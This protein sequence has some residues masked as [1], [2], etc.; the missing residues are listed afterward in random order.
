MRSQRLLGR[1][2]AG[3][4]C[5]S[6]GRGLGG[7]HDDGRGVVMT[8]PPPGRRAARTTKAVSEMLARLTPPAMAN[9]RRDAQVYAARMDSDPQTQSG[10]TFGPADWPLY[11]RRAQE[12][13]RCRR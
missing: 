5:G 2:I 4:D 6:E 9:A 3:N 13:L 7:V 8:A 1:S 10:E 11:E 12:P